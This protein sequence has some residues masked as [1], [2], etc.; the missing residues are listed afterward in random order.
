LSDTDGDLLGD[1]DELTM[2]KSN[3]A[4]VDSDGDARGSDGTDI[5]NPSLFDGQELLL[6]GTSPTL[7]DTDGDGMSDY[8]EILGGGFNPLRA[9]LP[10]IEISV[11]GDP[12]VQLKATFR[13]TSTTQTLRN[14]L[15]RDSSTDT[16]TDSQ[17]TRTTLSAST[18]I[19]AEAGGSYPPGVGYVKGTASA[20]A[21]AG[22]SRNTTSNQTQRS[23]RAAQEDFRRTIGSKESWSFSGGQIEV[24]MRLKNNSNVSLSIQDFSVVAFRVQPNR[25]NSLALVTTLRPTL[26]NLL[27]GGDGRVLGPGSDLL[28]TAEDT[29]VDSQK[30]LPLLENPTNLTYEIGGFS[31]S[32]TDSSGEATNDFAVIGQDVVE[33][34][35]MIV[36]DYGD[37]RVETHFVASNVRRNPDG[38]GAG[39]SVEEAL[40]TL[41]IP[42]E[43]G[44][45]LQNEALL[46][47]VRDKGF[48]EKGDGIDTPVVGAWLVIG[49]SNQ[50][51][52]PVGERPQDFN[53]LVLRNGDR[54]SFVYITDFDGDT[55][56]DR[57]EALYG[58]D[59]RTKDTDRDGIDDNVEVKSGRTINFG[60]DLPQFSY[61]VFSDPR[62]QDADFDGLMDKDE[63]DKGTDPN[64]FDTD[65]D[66]ID[67]SE[68][69]SPL[70]PP[71]QAGGL[72]FV[73]LLAHYEFDKNAVNAHN[74][75]VH[76]GV[77][78]NHQD[79]IWNL[80]RRPNE[81]G[82]TY[83][84]YDRIT[85]A[86][87]TAFYFNLNMNS[88]SSQ[89]RD[90]RGY[91]AVP[92]F[93][94]VLDSAT[95]AAWVY[96]DPVNANSTTAEG[97]VVVHEGWLSLSFDAGLPRFQLPS[98]D[99][100]HTTITGLANP[101]PAR[102]WTLLVGTYDSLTQT[103]SL[104]QD[105]V[106]VA[107]PTTANAVAPTNLGSPVMH[108]GSAYALFRSDGVPLGSSACTD[109]NGGLS[110]S[111]RTRAVRVDNGPS[112]IPEE[113]GEYFSGAID[114]V[115][116]FDRALSPREIENLYR[117]EGFPR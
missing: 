37:G 90:S 21:S 45:S 85:Q 110:Q 109:D 51:A 12:V 44:T 113:C 67:D 15:E 106:L 83:N 101:V 112:T 33:R 93:L 99:G 69:P 91:V 50:F 70:D 64:H 2:Y 88:I 49:S 40:T 59:P 47:V 14:T 75:T 41:R 18:Q 20:S 8:Q 98:G 22:V 73:G 36:I 111:E 74:P 84:F 55:L 43:V 80:D 56:W 27:P 31:L 77:I 5:P 46:S 38:S 4:R 28:F 52:L 13:A 96:P 79:A 114:D 53:K 34:C 95:I 89:A 30:M 25:S 97:G 116:I 29:E 104:F 81:D 6:S 26:E 65:G 24:A 78:N 86:V 63:E 61:E 92:S 39:I 16:Q 3:P 103:I 60:Q 42:Y 117:E 54:I 102:E 11:V 100:S 35:A 68:D 17:S 58:T 94:G 105:G 7:A 1:F 62:F 71:D 66:G 57:E 10:E 76:D 72:P 19:N 48:V 115:R 87:D 82:G 108:I 107:G 32:Q 9:D 23:V